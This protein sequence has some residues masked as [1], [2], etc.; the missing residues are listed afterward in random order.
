MKWHE[1]YKTAQE[2]AQEQFFY[3]ASPVQGIKRFRRSI[4]TSGNNK[5]KVLFAS[6]FPSFSAAF[7][8]RWNDGIAKLSVQTKN[9]QPPTKDNYVGTLL[10]YTDK[11]NMDSPCS[12]YKVKGNFKPLRYDNDIEAYTDSDT[13]I[14]SE[15]QFKSFKDMAKAYGL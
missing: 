3:H 9:Q 11:V 1:I 15:E 5:G 13:E 12:M 10:R 6:Q 7:G 2:Q 14:I 8:T 4:D